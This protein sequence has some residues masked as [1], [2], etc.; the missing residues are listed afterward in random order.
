MFQVSGFKTPGSTGSIPGIL[1]FLQKTQ[2]SSSF[3]KQ[4]PARRNTG[5][6]SLLDRAILFV[7]AYDNA[8]EISL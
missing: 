8:V 2:V 5:G 3:T 4:V 7:C 1:V 6:R